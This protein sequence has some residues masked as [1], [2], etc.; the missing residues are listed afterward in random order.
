MAEQMK[1]ILGEEQFALD[2]GERRIYGVIHHVEK[3]AAVVVSAHGLNGERVD[4]HRILV[5]FARECASNGVVSVRFDFSGCGITEG[6]FRHSTIKKRTEEIAA[7]VEYIRAVYPGVPVFCHGFSDG[8]RVVYDSFEQIK[9]DGCVFWSPILLPSQA[10]DADM[11]DVP[12]QRLSGERHP[13]KPFLGLWLGF[14]YIKEYGRL[15]EHG[16]GKTPV[17]VFRGKLD[18]SVD[19]SIKTILDSSEGTLCEIE[20]CGHIYETRA[21][22]GQIIAQTLLWITESCTL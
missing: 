9:P 21:A 6:E 10:D 18:R 2:V 15:N 1:N 20:D 13:V 14:D 5:L 19:N 3:P 4:A 22:T 12:W 16:F 17:R 7:V 11:T 8:S